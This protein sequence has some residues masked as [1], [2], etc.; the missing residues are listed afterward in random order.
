MIYM[1]VTMGGIWDWEQK[2]KMNVYADVYALAEILKEKDD[3]ADEE[4]KEE[5][6]E[7]G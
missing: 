6:E 4:S 7:E 3:D 2:T 1:I 5:E